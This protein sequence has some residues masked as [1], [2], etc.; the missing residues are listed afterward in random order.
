VSHALAYGI[1]V[2][3]AVALLAAACKDPA[4]PAE[5]LAKLPEAQLRYPRGTYVGPSNGTAGLGTESSVS[6]F[7]IGTNDDPDDLASWY[8]GQLLVLGWRTGAQGSPRWTWAKGELSAVLDCESQF[9]SSSAAASLRTSD[10]VC[11]FA[12]T[13]GPRSPS[14]TTALSGGTP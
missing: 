13:A 3:G 12:L 4:V 5:Q 10:V 8:A 11:E 1:G 9:R 7:L 14:T 2:L 6:Q